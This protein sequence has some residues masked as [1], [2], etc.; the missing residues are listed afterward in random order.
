MLYL[1]FEK[2]ENKQKEAEFGPFF[3]KKSKKSTFVK[4]NSLEG[5]EVRPDEESKCESK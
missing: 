2:N 5:K 1:S 3:L 4:I